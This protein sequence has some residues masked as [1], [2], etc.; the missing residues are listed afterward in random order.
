MGFNTPNIGKSAIGKNDVAKIF[1]RMAIRPNAKLD[2]DN[3]SKEVNK[4]EVVQKNQSK[5]KVPRNSPC[6]CGSGK[7]YKHC[8]GKIS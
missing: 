4:S 6:P 2:H 8:H 5:K 3:E 1:S 7:K